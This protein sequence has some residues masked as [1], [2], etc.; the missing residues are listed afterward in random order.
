VVTNLVRDG[1]AR[2]GFWETGALAPGDYTLRVIAE[3]FFGNRA[4]RDM[5]VAVVKE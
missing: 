3:D 1:E 4:R 2:E 5:A